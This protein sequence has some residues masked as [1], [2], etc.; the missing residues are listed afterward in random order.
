MLCGQA[1]HRGYACEKFKKNRKEPKKSVDKTATAAV[2]IA[3]KVKRYEKELAAYVAAADMVREIIEQVPGVNERL[4]LRKRYLA[5][6]PWEKIA[7]EMHYSVQRVYQIH[8]KAL[9]EVREIGE[10]K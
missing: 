5:F 3:D 10:K 9:D 6:E 1:A 2:K 8:K 7:E 4:V